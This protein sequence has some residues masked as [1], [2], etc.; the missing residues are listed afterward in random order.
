MLTLIAL[1][2]AAC[3]A[4]AAS[5]DSG[6]THG[7]KIYL[8]RSRAHFLL[9]NLSFPGVR[10]IHGDPPVFLVDGF[11]SKEECKLWRVEAKPSLQR[12]TIIIEANADTSEARTSSSA[13]LPK[14][15]WLERRIADLTAWPPDTQEPPQISRYARGEHYTLHYD[16]FDPRPAGSHNRAPFLYG[17]RTRT[18]LIARTLHPPRPSVPGGQRIATI[19][20]YLN[21]PARGGA[22]HFPDLD[23]RVTP[24][25]GSALVFFPATVGEL[26]QDGKWCTPLHCPLIYEF[27]TLALHL[28]TATSTVS[29]GTKPRM[30]L[31]RSGSCKC[32][33]GKLPGQ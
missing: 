28:Q 27:I 19:L 5:G 12:S 32:G 21:S 14:R 9:L 25:E 20:I 11:L 31:I 1:A 15:D 7:P 33:C 6:D 26:L 16:H 29:R 22:T 4:H 23:L 17:V 2:A 30:L 3:V 24:L 13:T 8:D 18:I 10:R